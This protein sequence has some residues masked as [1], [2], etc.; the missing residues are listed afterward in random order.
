VLYTYLSIAVGGLLSILEW[1]TAKD[2]LFLYV[3][4]GRELKAESNETGPCPTLA[5]NSTAQL[6][7]TSTAS[8]RSDTE[9]CYNDIEQVMCLPRVLFMNIV[10][11]GHEMRGKRNF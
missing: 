6:N 3:D 10:E 2:G 8:N 9:Y 5:G 11:I 7:A 1:Y 4:L